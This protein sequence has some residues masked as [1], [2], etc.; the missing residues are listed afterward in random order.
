MKIIYNVIIRFLEKNEDNLFIYIG[1][2][3]NNQIVL[4]KI[5]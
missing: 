1:K 4:E 2:L 3:I 5:I